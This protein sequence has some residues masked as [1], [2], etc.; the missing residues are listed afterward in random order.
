MGFLFMA[1][2]YSPVSGVTLDPSSVVMPRVSHAGVSPG[3][4]R[5]VSRG[6]GKFVSEANLQITER[7]L[8]LR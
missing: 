2:I 1:N 7:E 8:R 6:A 5:H 3:V 4:M